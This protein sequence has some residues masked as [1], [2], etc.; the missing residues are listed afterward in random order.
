MSVRIQPKDKTLVSFLAEE[1]I[2]ISKEN[3]QVMSWETVEPEKLPIC[4]V[5]VVSRKQNAFVLYNK[6]EFKKYK[7]EREGY[8][9]QYFIVPIEKL[10]NNSNLLEYRAFIEEDRIHTRNQFESTREMLDDIAKNLNRTKTA[11]DISK[12][13]KF[14]QKSIKHIAQQLRMRGVKIPHSTKSR[15]NL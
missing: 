3:F 2:P 13:Y 11:E 7:T 12:Q 4:L 15:F 14:P 5:E 10:W 1:A 6:E 9:Y 8:T